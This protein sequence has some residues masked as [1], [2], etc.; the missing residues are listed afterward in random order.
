MYN[1][2]LA[3]LCQ[4]QYHVNIRGV[5][6]ETSPPPHHTP[7]PSWLYHP[8]LK[9]HR[10]YGSILLSRPSVISW[11]FWPSAFPLS[12]PDVWYS[13]RISASER[14]SW[15][16]HIPIDNLTLKEQAACSFMVKV[17]TGMWRSPHTRPR[18]STNIYLPDKQ[19]VLL[20][21]YFP[22]NIKHASDLR[23]VT[24]C[25]IFTCVHWQKR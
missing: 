7:R 17:S 23:N 6:N 4:C 9:G 25:W 11:A 10:V 24:A 21:R 22:R 2:V 1:N 19:C 16:R 20:R 8:V 3:S 14:A 5:W 18:T 15:K 13:M 12:P